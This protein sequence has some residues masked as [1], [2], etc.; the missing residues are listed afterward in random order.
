M[1]M[2][3]RL[4]RTIEKAIPEEVRTWI[5][6]RLNPAD[7]VAGAIIAAILT[8]LG[9]FHFVSSGRA[10]VTVCASDA[11]HRARAAALSAQAAST[12]TT[13]TAR[14]AADSERQAPLTTTG[15]SGVIV[16]HVA[17]RVS[18]PGI[19][20]LPASSR[21]YD[22]VARAAPLPDACLDALNLAERLED[23]MR[24]YVPSRSEVVASGG[25]EAWVV[26][27]G[28]S[29]SNG[30]S[31]FRNRASKEAPPHRVDLNAATARDLEEL[32]GIGPKTAQKIIE[33]RDQNGFFR[34][35]NDLLE[36]PGIGE[37]KL[38]NIKPYV[39]VR[40]Q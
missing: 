28:T 19:V 18:H 15:A 37:K 16:V 26:R 20:S 4:V 27:S 38:E 21:V 2:R 40:G 22:A 9:V 17:G 23:G 35:V 11:Q 1:T 33:Y 29:V 6:E 34:S 7:I 25:I 14:G 5:A 12:I 13:G 36:I 8:A 24:I 39:F 3:T 32:P 31:A 10:S 30:S